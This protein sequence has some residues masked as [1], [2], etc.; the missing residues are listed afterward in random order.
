[1]YGLLLGF[2]GSWHCVVMC[3][4]ILSF[5][6]NEGNKNYWALVLYH[7]GRISIYALLGYL[8]ALLG[9]IGLFTRYW[10]IYLVLVALFIALL[11]IGIIKD[12]NFSFLHQVIGQRIYFFGKK[13]G[14][15]KFLFFGMGNGFLPCGLVMAGLSTSL[16][17]SSSLNGAINMIYFGLGTIPALLFT[18]LGF[19]K[20]NHHKHFFANKLLKFISWI[21]VFAL[22]F[23]GIWG[24]LA[25]IFDVVKYHPLTPIICH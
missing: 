16:I 22:L 4:P 3:G 1:M 17:Q 10:Y 9:T 21:V 5:F 13:T 15:F 18:I 14:K 19:N 7:L 23:Q 24:I 12:Q 20:V 8:V 25:Q 2:T 11:L 6:F